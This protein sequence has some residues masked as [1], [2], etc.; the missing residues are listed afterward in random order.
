[1]RPIPVTLEWVPRQDHIQ[2]K[3]LAMTQACSV[4][5][6]LLQLFP[7]RQ[8]AQLVKQHQAGYNAQGFPCREQFVAMLFCQAA[9]LNSLRE[10][11]LGLAGCESP[12]KH[13]GILNGGRDL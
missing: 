7:R 8:F 2:R 3:G 4:Y 6:Q 1:M 5:S 11:C 12:P 13:L 9:H 10:V